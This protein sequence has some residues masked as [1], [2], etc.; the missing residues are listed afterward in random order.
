MPCFVTSCSAVKNVVC[1][2]VT[3][4]VMRLP[5]LEPDMVMQLKQR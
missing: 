2:S 5:S 1:P 4:S 3:V